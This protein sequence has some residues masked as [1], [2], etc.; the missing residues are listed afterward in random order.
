M[1]RILFFLI[2]IAASLSLSAQDLIVTS[3]RDSINCKVTK[4]DQDNIYYTVN[5]QAGVL[6]LIKVKACL[7]N[8]YLQKL[9]TVTQVPEIQEEK[10][11]SEPLSE[12]DNDFKRFRFG[13]SGGYGYRTYSLS[14]G[15]TTEL[16]NYYN[17]LRWGLV[18][19]ADATYFFSKKGGLGIHSSFY[20]SSNS[21]DNVWLFVNSFL[22]SGKIGD[23]ISIFY[24]GPSFSRSLL[25]DD[26][27][28]SLLF[29][30]SG[31]YTRYINNL[32]TI[33]DYKLTSNSFGFSLQLAYDRA[34]TK[35]LSVGIQASITGGS[36]NK[37]TQEDSSGTTSYYYNESLVR[38]DLGAG[39]RF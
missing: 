1:K 36:I 38:F 23:D 8:Y 28:N 25:E 9:P 7:Y 31:G 3:S 22:E 37:I 35:G 39:I 30:V 2:L 17:K 10:H 5:G 34:I 33:S 4:V 24:V 12:T 20:K 29:T 19:N 14:S 13:L 21:L 11:E 32:V 15:L 6:P 27:F 16:T 26:G 18:V